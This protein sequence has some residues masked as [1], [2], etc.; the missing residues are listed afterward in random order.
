[1]EGGRNRESRAME[2]L[3]R[4]EHIAPKR[5]RNHDVVGNFDS[6]HVEIPFLSTHNILNAQLGD[7][8]VLPKKTN[9]G[10]IRMRGCGRCP[11]P[12][13]AGETE[14]RHDIC[15]SSSWVCDLGVS[16]AHTAAEK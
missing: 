7:W 12:L 11:S 4:T 13:P 8:V 3:S 16:A 10:H 14:Q 9:V 2:S 1:H 5:V 15:D 6:V